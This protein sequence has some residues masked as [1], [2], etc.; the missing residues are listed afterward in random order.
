M[1]EKL[2]IEENKNTNTDLSVGVQQPV[3]P[4]EVLAGGRNKIILTTY[5]IF[6]IANYAGLKV[7]MPDDDDKEIEYLLDDDMDILIEDD[8]ENYKGL[9]IFTVEYPDEGALPLAIK[10]A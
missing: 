3:M 8:N 7:E 6:E 10:P 4:N 9:G 5:Q 1:E 2:N